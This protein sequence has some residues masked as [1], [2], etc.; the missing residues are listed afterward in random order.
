MSKVCPECN[1]E[2][3][4]YSL[5]WCKPCNSTRFKNDFGKWTSGNDMTSNLPKPKNEEN[6]EREL[7]ELTES[8]YQINARKYQLIL[9]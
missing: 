6:F 4:Q 7:K 1:Q 3:D 8:F 5:W 9:H 2:Y